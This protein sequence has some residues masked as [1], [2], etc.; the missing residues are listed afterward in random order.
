LSSLPTTAS[1]V[2]GVAWSPN[3][4]TLADAGLGKNGGV[5]ELWNASTGK[6]MT[7]LPT[8][9]NHGVLTAAFSPDGK[10]LADGGQN[11]N[12]GALE[13][14]DVST[15]KLTLLPTAAG[16]IYAVAFSPDGKTLAAA[17][18]F[19]GGVLELW[20]IS[21]GKRLASLP[22]TAVEGA[23]AVAFSPDGKTVVSGGENYSAGILEVWSVS[24]HKLITSYSTN[25]ISTV[26]FSPDGA[27]LFAGT[28]GNGIQVFSTANW[29]LLTSYNN[30]PDGNVLSLALSHDHLF[31]AFGTSSGEIGLANNLFYQAVAGL[32]IPG[33]GVTAGSQV[34]ATVT[35]AEPAPAGGATV[36]LKSNSTG[37]TVPSSVKVAAGS[38]SATF[39]IS[40][41]SSLTTETRAAITASYG[42]VS[43]AATLL[44]DPNASFTPSLSIGTVKGGKSVTLTVTL[45]KAAPAGGLTFYF[46]SDNTALAWP[47]SSAV[48]IAA[49]A[50]SA[51][52]IFNTKAVSSN[53]TV[54]LTSTLGSTGKSVALTVTP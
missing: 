17:G 19:P 21:T 54:H 25:V 18:E 6:Q 30:L 41:S 22:T 36:T 9:V 49:G 43:K 1:A 11:G 3:G 40:G 14:W 27:N 26:A 29:G 31:L 28:D 47:R 20:N 34:T 12:V 13:L 2:N 46:G 38:T 52:V 15:G 45:A 32:A 8:T 39:P 53:T 44:A 16:R 23:F 51:P 5:L 50:T 48:K 7:T 37:V 42:S 33:T 35:L 10:T 4:K 24:A